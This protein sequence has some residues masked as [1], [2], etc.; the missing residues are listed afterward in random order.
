M[1]F[2]YSEAKLDAEQRK[3]LPNSSYGLPE[4][5]K[6]PLTDANHVR[7]AMRYFKSCP[8]EKRKALAKRILSAA[9]KYGVDISEDSDVYK[10]AHNESKHEDAFD[11]FDAK[12][13]AILEANKKK[14]DPAAIIDDDP[15]FDYTADGDSSD[16]DTP[17]DTEEGTPDY[18]SELGSNDPDDDDSS[19]GDYDPDGP[20]DVPEVD[21]PENDQST[22]TSGDNPI[23]IGSDP[24]STPAPANVNTAE[25]PTTNND[26]SPSTDQQPAPADSTTGPVSAEPAPANTNNQSPDQT[27]PTEDPTT[28]DDTPDYT[29]D[30][31]SDQPN[32]N[33][34]ID[35]NSN[36]DVKSDGNTTDATDTQD[37][38]SDDDT[39]D[40]DYTSDADSEGEPSLDMD[41]DDAEDGT[42]DGTSDN[43]DDSSMDDTGGDVGGGSG[44]NPELQKLQADAFANLTD[45][46]IKIR[47]D[48]IKD[49]FINLYNNIN[50]TIERLVDINKSSDIAKTVNYINTELFELKDMVRDALTISFNARSMIE[51][52][53]VLQ[54]AI[55]IYSMILGVIEKI[56][57]KEEKK[58]K[59]DN[60]SEESD[61]K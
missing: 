16:A 61:T 12:Y 52:E 22:D 2:T 57:D 28:T 23:N 43:S 7:S 4:E 21:T 39:G 47:T 44:V 53:L 42:D 48:Q 26:T 1:F 37:T 50:S 3:S 45:E 56:S 60:K 11:S 24:A 54:K 27:P 5:R 19:D 46:Q 33:P 10:A 55:A 31:A 17:E 32:S 6:F 59:K 38:T 40:T 9:K 35:N 30:N 15:A 29:A 13:S 58:N 41:G 51:N 20:D 25:E 34:S 14:N 49:S 36:T 8:P 18:T